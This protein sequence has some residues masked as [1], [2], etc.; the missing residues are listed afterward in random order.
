MAVASVAEQ[1]EENGSTYDFILSVCDIP[2]IG[3]SHLLGDD[4]DCNH[5]KLSLGLQLGFQFAGVLFC[6]VFVL[7]RR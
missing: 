5:H 7:A 3:L 4:L 6:I 1:Q 2:L